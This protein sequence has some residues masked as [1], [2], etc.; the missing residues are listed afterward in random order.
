MLT[1]LNQDFGNCVCALRCKKSTENPFAPHFVRRSTQ[2]TLIIVCSFVVLHTQ[3]WWINGNNFYTR[4]HTSTSARSSRA[5]LSRIFCFFRSIGWPFLHICR[6]QCAIILN[7]FFC[8]SHL[9]GQTF[10][11]SYNANDSHTHRHKRTLSHDRIHSNY[12]AK[13]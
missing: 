11:V 12:L 3:R 2:M 7:I 6:V 13:L 4:T 10:R 1:S 8:I 9:L 5:F